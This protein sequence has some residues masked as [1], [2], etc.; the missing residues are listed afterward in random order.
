MFEPWCVECARAS[1]PGETYK[2][3][4][5]LRHLRSLPYTKM[6]ETNSLHARNIFRRLTVTVLFLTANRGGVEWFV[7]TVLVG[8]L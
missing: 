4:S 3:H 8:G 6:L 7:A 5:L 1:C 2:L